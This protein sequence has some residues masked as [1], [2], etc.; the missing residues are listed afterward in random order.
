MNNSDADAL[1]FE[2]TNRGLAPPSLD[3]VLLRD[4]ISGEYGK[5]QFRG[6]TTLLNRCPFNERGN[7]TN[8]NVCC[9]IH[10]NARDCIDFPAFELITVGIGW[11]LAWLGIY[12]H[13]TFPSVFPLIP[14][15]FGI[16]VFTMVGFLLLYLS[17]FAYVFR[18]SPIRTIPVLL[19]SLE[20]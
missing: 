9:L 19:S 4:L 1:A 3:R 13:T 14:I 20:D 2:L 17:T 8:R 7:I 6:L 12:L 10:G 16:T 11:K 18:I 5:R 15:P